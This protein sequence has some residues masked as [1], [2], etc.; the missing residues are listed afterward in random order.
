MIVLHRI[1]QLTYVNMT[2]LQTFSFIPLL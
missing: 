1:Y 2:L